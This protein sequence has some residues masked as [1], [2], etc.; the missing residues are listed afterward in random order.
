MNARDFE[1]VVAAQLEREGYR[2]ELGPGKGDWGVDLFAERDGSRYAVQAKMYGRTPRPI[3]RQMVMELHGA[4]AFFDCAGS[5]LATNGGRVLEDA[6]RVA[7]KLGIAILDVPDTPTADDRR[8]TAAGRSQS[9]QPDF[10]TIW[11]RYV[12]PLEGRTLTRSNGES[13]EI[14]TVDWAGVERVTSNGRRQ[15]IGIEVFRWTIE[16]L[17][18][19]G[20]VTRSAINDHY[21]GRASSGIVL[22]LGQVPLFELTANPVKL[23]LRGR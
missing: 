22:I 4:A 12:M 1:E 6:R 19:T 10:A 5:M 14:V 20:C 8:G 13:N 9:S 2:V 16:R 17:L 3:N 15:R 18:E 11:E 21:V 7:D 23:Q